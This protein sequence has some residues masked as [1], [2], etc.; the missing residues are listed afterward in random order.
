MRIMIKILAFAFPFFYLLQPSTLL[1]QKPH[2]GDTLKISG[3]TENIRIPAR[4]TKQQ[5]I[6]KIEEV[7]RNELNSYIIEMQNQK[8]ISDNV[9]SEVKL[10]M[11][12][13]NGTPGL[14]IVYSYSL[15]NDTLKY[16]TDDFTLGNY[17]VNGSNAAMVTLALMKRSLQGELKKYITPQKEVSITIN[18]NADATTIRKAIPYKGEYG[19]TINEDCEVKGKQQTMAVSITKGITDNNTL[20][21]MRSYA[22]RDYITNDIEVLKQTRNN[23][24]HKALVSEFQGGKYR[25]VSIEIIVHNAFENSKP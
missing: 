5:E 22:V 17:R 11:V 19:N 23:F 16:Q 25:R 8:F 14:K 24:H 20:A 13:E 9:V 3:S 6:A 2:P 4:M 1:A 12:D 15:K 7:L 21:F 18:G 10:D